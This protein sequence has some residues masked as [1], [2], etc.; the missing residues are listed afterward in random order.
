MDINLF[1]KLKNKLFSDLNNEK[2]IC[3]TQT[4]KSGIENAPKDNNITIEY[5]EGKINFLLFSWEQLL[6]QKISA[7]FANGIEFSL[8]SMGT[9]SS[10]KKS[11]IFIITIG[12]DNLQ[13]KIFQK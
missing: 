9:M 5:K 11:F 1:N 6:H 3:K 4:D 8:S 12:S 13:H 7:A 10:S 2:S